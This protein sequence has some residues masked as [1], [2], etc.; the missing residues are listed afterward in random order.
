M[1]WCLVGKC[2]RARRRGG[3]I[4]TRTKLGGE[5]EAAALTIAIL[6]LEAE[7]GPLASCATVARRAAG[8]FLKITYKEGEG[9][10]ELRDLFLGQGVSLL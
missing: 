6:I 10:L 1:L 9:L 2:A 5:E 4:V 8:S 3:S 7:N